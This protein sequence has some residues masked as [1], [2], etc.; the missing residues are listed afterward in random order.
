M[1]ELRYTMSTLGFMKRNQK[2]VC[3]VYQKG[4]E[5]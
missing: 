1:K 5:D 2:Y 3:K 4:L